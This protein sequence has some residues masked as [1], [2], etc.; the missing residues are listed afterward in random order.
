MMITDQVTLRP[1]VPADKDL[2]IEL[3][4]SS[5]PDMDLVP[6]ELA[7]KTEFFRSQFEIRARWYAIRWPSAEHFIIHVEGNDAGSLIT[8]RSGES[9]VVVDIVVEPTHRR[10]GIA[11]SMIG[12]LQDEAEAFG[13]PIE[14]KVDKLNAAARNLY[15]RSGFE[16]L[17]EDATLLRLRWHPRSPIT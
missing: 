15:D 17:D 11:R 1:A 9:I 14:L 16:T 2:L 6:W 8:D 12:I 3:Y 7:A 10:K 4:A 13:R 5:R